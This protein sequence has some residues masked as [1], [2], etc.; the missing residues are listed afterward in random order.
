MTKPGD[1]TDTNKY[2]YSDYGLGF[3]ST[4]QFSHSQGGMARNII[5]FGVDLSKSVHAINKTWSNSK[6]NNTTIYAEK[7]IHLILLQKTKYFA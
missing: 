5:I 3:D 6:S 1:T 4:G 2:I 7:C